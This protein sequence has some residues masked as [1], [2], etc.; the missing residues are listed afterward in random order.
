MRLFED[1]NH[2]VDL[3]EELLMVPPWVTANTQIN[4]AVCILYHIPLFIVDNESSVFFLNEVR[5]MDKL[6]APLLHELL[7]TQVWLSPS[8]PFSTFLGDKIHGAYHAAALYSFTWK[9]LSS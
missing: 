6:A 7:L 8:R 3:H 5:D 4:D 9:E 1:L 2:F